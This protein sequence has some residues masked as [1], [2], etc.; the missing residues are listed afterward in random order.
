MPEGASIK[1]DQK[2]PPIPENIPIKQEQNSDSLA[3]LF[4]N[5]FRPHVDPKRFIFEIDSFC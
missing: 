2:M 5:I 3:L 4:A 1:V